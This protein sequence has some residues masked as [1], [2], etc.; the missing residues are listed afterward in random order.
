MKQDDKKIKDSVNRKNFVP[1]NYLNQLIQNLSNPRFLGSI[2]LKKEL[3]PN[4]SQVKDFITN[5]NELT[6]TKTLKN[7]ISNP[8]TKILIISAIIFNIFWFFLIYFL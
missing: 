1:S 5:Q 8:I 4:Y 6:M 2:H 3:N 7:A